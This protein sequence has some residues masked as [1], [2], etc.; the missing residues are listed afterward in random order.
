MTDPDTS[1]EPSHDSKSSASRWLSWLGFL[2]IPLALYFANVEMQSYLGRQA[3]EDTGLEAL[4]LDHALAKANTE[5]KLVLADMSAIWCPTCRKLDKEIFA[6]ESVKQ[7]LSEQFIFARVEYESDEGKAFMDK[8]QVQG[9]PTLLIL[10]GKGDK[11]SQL[12]LT[13]SPDIFIGLL[14]KF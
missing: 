9:F 8:Y 12:P 6:N 5:G 7:A 10:D 13:F 11:L 3:L 14:Q 2:A 1:N 4:S